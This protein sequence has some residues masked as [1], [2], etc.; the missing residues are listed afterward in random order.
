VPRAGVRIDDEMAFFSRKKMGHV[1]GFAS[2]RRRATKV[3]LEKL[4]FGN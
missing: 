2:V 1:L 3:N 4:F